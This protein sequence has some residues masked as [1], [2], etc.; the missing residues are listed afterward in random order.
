[1]FEFLK[2]VCKPLYKSKGKNTDFGNNFVKISDYNSLAFIEKLLRDLA[3]WKIIT[4]VS[5][6][7]L[8]GM[9]CCNKLP[10]LGLYSQDFI[11]EIEV[12]GVIETD[13]F[14][15]KVLKE[16]A[17]DKNLK[18]VFL[19]INS[20]GGTITGSEILYGEIKKIS[21]KVPVYA[22]IYDLGASGGYMIALGANKIYSH[23]TSIT[24]SIGVLMQTLQF[25]EL[26]K[27]VGARMKVYRSVPFKAQPDPFEKT[28]PEVD[29]YMQTSIEESHKFFANLVAK[30]RKF[31]AEEILNVA[32]GKIFM[33][34]EALKLK[35]IDGIAD[36]QFVKSALMKKVGKLE[37]E[38]V[39]LKKEA[40]EGF[41]S[42][43]IDDILKKKSKESSKSKVMAIMK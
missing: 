9:L 15:S 30:E 13:K 35:L 34:S 22:L 37:F 25:E 20:P 16:L 33:G 29:F 24:G 23:E 8:I 19:K 27:K 4:F 41:V 3:K 42:Q 28:T 21:N 10:S 11:A 7:L 6:L 14:R 18:G 38:E 1:M 32:N 43:I 36:E 2:K 17:E 39:S 40:D 31:S 5:I 26:S 12:D